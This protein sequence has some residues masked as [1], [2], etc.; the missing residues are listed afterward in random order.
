ML[1]YPHGITLQNSAGQEYLFLFGSLV[2]SATD[3]TEVFCGRH[4][5]NRNEK[6]KEI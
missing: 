4:S 3:W 6:L 5:F 2:F 1:I